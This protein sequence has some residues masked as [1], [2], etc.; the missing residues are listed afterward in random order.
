[1]VH[2]P[3]PT[4]VLGELLEFCTRIVATQQPGTYAT[5]SI[6]PGGAWLF[7]QGYPL[8]TSQQQAALFDRPPGVVF[9]FV[10]RLAPADH[11]SPP[12]TTDAPSPTAIDLRDV[13]ERVVTTQDTLEYENCRI[14]PSSAEVFLRV[15]RQLSPIDRVKL[16]SLSAAHAME[17]VRLFART[18]PIDSPSAADSSP[19]PDD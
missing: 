8:L 16:L 1:M 13:C 9:R 14:H 3:P 19:S 11:P 5:L 17:L 2:R 10:C 4:D 7:L 15:Y 6:T 18:Y 12:P